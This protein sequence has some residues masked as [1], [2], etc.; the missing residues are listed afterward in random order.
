MFCPLSA[1]VCF[2]QSVAIQIPLQP[3]V[4]KVEHYS[5]THHHIPETAV[6]RET[7]TVQVHA[8]ARVS[9]GVMS[10]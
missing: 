1:L 9:V 2:Y 6:D 7:D 5:V 10:N 4:S 3:K 8:R